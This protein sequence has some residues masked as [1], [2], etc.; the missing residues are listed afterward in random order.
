MPETKRPLSARDVAKVMHKIE[1]LQAS[2]KTLAE[3]CRAN[4]ISQQTYVRL[5][6]R[7]GA[8]RTPAGRLKEL[9]AENRRLKRSIDDISLREALLREVLKGN[10]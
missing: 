9:Q 6:R 3:A 7:N 5:R 1:A 2:G 10:Y 8:Y 4:G